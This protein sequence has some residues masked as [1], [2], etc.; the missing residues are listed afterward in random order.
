MFA[1]HMF[2]K[3]PVSRFYKEVLQLN[4]NTREFWKV[5]EIFDTL[6][7]VGV[8]WLQEKLLEQV[9]LKWVHFN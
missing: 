1:K 7:G 5:I 9:P 2:D 8:W 3:E 4:N 6:I